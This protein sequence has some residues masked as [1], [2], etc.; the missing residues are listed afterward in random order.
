MQHSKQ[1]LAIARIRKFIYFEQSKRL[2][3][4]YIMWTFTYFPLIWMYF[5]KTTNNL[6]DKIQKRS[7]RVIY[8]MED[9]NFKHLLIKDSSWTIH[10]NNIYK[11][12]VKIYEY[13][14]QISPAIMQGF[15]DLKVTPYSLRNNNI[16]RLPKT[17]T[18]QYGTEA[19]CFKGSI[20]WNTVPN[21]Y[22][23]LNSL[24]KFK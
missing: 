5:S 22:K 23:N 24:D 2:P 21:R 12:L 9:A 6:I 17:N 7:L 14:N 18:S 16:L 10:E 3:E 8:E 11:L 4:A 19:L 13:L 20:L 15:F 1:P